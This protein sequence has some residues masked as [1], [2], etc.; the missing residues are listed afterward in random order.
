MSTKPAV[1]AEPRPADVAAKELDALRACEDEAG[2][3]LDPVVLG[4]PLAQLFQAHQSAKVHS[5]G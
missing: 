5:G 4:V 3:A 1:P 2:T